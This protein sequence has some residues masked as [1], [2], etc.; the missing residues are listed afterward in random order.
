MPYA[1]GPRLMI[2]W[3]RHVPMHVVLFSLLGPQQL[4]PGDNSFINIIMKLTCYQIRSRTRNQS[5]C[6]I[7]WFNFRCSIIH[8]QNYMQTSFFV[9]LKTGVSFKQSAIM[10]DNPTLLFNPPSNQS[11]DHILNQNLLLVTWVSATIPA[12]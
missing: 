3:F 6:T 9:T 1:C 11:T 2:F 8:C 12:V 5:C 10:F 7:I 4:S